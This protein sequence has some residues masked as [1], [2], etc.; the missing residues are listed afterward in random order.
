MDGLGPGTW[1]ASITEIPWVEHES[2]QI[3]GNHDKNN[4]GSVRSLKHLQTIVG[5]VPIPVHTIWKEIDGWLFVVKLHE[6]NQFLRM[7]RKIGYDCKSDLWFG[8]SQMLA[9]PDG[10]MNDIPK[11]AFFF[12]MVDHPPIPVAVSWSGDFVHHEQI[13]SN[14]SE[15]VTKKNPCWITLR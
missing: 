12:V 8:E 11:H 5:H 2:D 3:L 13:L 4:H 14:S 9:H 6:I 10:S 15:R 1:E 7:L